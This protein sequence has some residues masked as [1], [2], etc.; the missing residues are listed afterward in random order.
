MKALNIQDDVASIISFREFPDIESLSSSEFMSRGRK[1]ITNRVY[2][3]NNIHIIIW[4][5]CNISPSLP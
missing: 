5:F 1:K 3:M 4:D 2:T